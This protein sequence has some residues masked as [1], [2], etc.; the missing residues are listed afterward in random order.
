MSLFT[1]SSC[2]AA[3]IQV[4]SK[5]R[6]LPNALQPWRARSVESANAKDLATHAAPREREGSSEGWRERF[7]R[8]TRHT[9]H[10]LLFETIKAPL[11]ASRAT[12]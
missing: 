7:F 12:G 9:V 6:L 11:T 1:V 5:C 10:G 4:R 8:G 3:A 2:V